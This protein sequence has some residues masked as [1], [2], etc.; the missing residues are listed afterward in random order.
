MEPTPAPIAETE[1]GSGAVRVDRVEDFRPGRS[2]LVRA[3]GYE[4]AVY[5]VDGEYLAIDNA[6]PHHG[7]ALVDGRV[8][9]TSVVCPWHGWQVDLRTG[10]CFQAPYRPAATYPVEV[11]DGAVWVLV[12]EP[13]V[14]AGPQPVDV[15][16]RRPLL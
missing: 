2:R 16:I 14:P 3:R 6:C 11:R 8:V 15:M 7:A 5:N 12:P 13:L 10:K 1:S 9:G 4:I